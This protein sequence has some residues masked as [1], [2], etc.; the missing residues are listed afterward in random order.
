[1]GS[2]WVIE[3][4][5]L[6]RRTLARWMSGPPLG[7]DVRT[8]ANTRDAEGGLVS[9]SS[10]DGLVLDQRFPGCED[11][12]DLLARHRCGRLRGTHV[13]L[14]T[15]HAAP[16]VSRKAYSLDAALLIKPASYA[17]FAPF[18]ATVRAR[19]LTRRTAALP[20]RI[21]ARVV[22]F[23]KRWSLSPRQQEVVV[24][25][26]RGLRGREVATD[27]R[28]SPETVGNHVR[29]ILERSHLQDMAEVVRDI[30]FDAQ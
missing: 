17:C 20:D 9:L 1:M 30:L 16:D 23:S 13:A 14:L 29:V 3:D 6:L 19:S 15:G 22:A 27:L 26:V 5:A 8:F 4:D 2:V 25:F 24:L 21:A 28:L 11:G 12:L 18:V 10:P 7:F